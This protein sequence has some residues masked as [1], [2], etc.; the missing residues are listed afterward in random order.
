[1]LEALPQA[2]TFLHL[3][4]SVLGPIQGLLFTGLVLVFMFFR[5]QG[6]V[7]AVG[8]WGAPRGRAGQPQGFRPWRASLRGAG[9]TRALAA[10]LSHVTS[11]SRS[12]V[13]ALSG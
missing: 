4:P 2:I 6:L 12:I 3:P 11:V 9:A 8:V 5:P 1:L 7:S 13:A 10:L